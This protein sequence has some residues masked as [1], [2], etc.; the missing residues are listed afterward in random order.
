MN[1]AAIYFQ[2][3]EYLEPERRIFNLGSRYIYK[4]VNED[5]IL[6]ISRTVNS[7]HIEG[8]FNISESKND[9][10]L[11]S[12]IVGQ[13]GVGKSSI[14]DVIRSNFIKNEYALPRS[15]SMLLIED[16][17]KVYFISR[18]LKAPVLL[19]GLTSTNIATLPER[20]I[21]T[22]FY[23]PHLDLKFNPNF[24]EI[25]HFDI[26][27]DRYLEMD[28]LDLNR[29]Q[30]NE[31]GIDY[32]VKQELLFKRA[33]RQIE[34]MSS[35]MMTNNNIFAGTFDFPAHGNAVLE[36][37]GTVDDGKWRN[38]PS[39]FNSPLKSLQRLI[40]K[41][42]DQWTTI[43]TD[44]EKG[45]ISNQSEVNAYLFQRY[46][47]KDILSVLIHQME[48]R[49]DYYQKGK[50]NFPLNREWPSDGQTAYQAF[51]DYLERCNV[52]TIGSQTPFDP[53][54]VEALVDKLYSL[55]KE[56]NHK[57]LLS[58]RKLILES[59]NAIEVLRLH[60]EFVLE[61][62][63]YYNKQYRSDS[64]DFANMNF[65]VQGFIFYSPAR[66]KLSS[67]ENAVLNLFSK[68][69][70]LIENRHN[71][72]F[73]PQPQIR[74]YVLLLD[75]AD[76]GYH[77]I[78]KKKFVYAMARCL[79]HFF[80]RYSQKPS[81]QL[82]FTTHDPLTLSDLPN[83]NVVY[84]LNTGTGLSE[85]KNDKPKHTFAA[86]ITDLLAD[87]FFVGDG[88][89][90]DFA[91]EKIQETIKWLKNTQNKQNSTT[92]RKIISMIDEPIIKRKLAEMFDNKMEEEFQLELI[93]R[94]IN[95]LNKLK[96][97]IKKK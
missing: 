84:L 64:N 42:L 50:F 93:E 65:L 90:G 45:N 41:E 4:L 70:D 77:P 61:V 9:L 54:T 83:K 43:R 28:L 34:F 33:K 29:H 40:E 6:T 3:H 26:S 89:V 85:P 71:P 23:S 10:N 19:E 30:K 67:G 76:L 37:R 74:H 12:A 59:S 25:D 69:Y 60:K 38:V 78:W 2:D 95:E 82:I 62:S 14:L 27:M 86:N 8:F 48:Q 1:I 52:K 88:L 49:G 68:L 32:S 46:I 96:S 44:D 80:E 87:S 51:I 15:N 39:A 91:K 63:N 56:E 7:T 35:G 47:L 66:R 57:N 16:G 36:M 94:Q 92:Y 18:N 24:D 20:E 5:E 22:I 55:S 21:Q 11:I 31:Y 79:P 13:N 58:D 53:E 75:E 97:A 73:D 17:R 72:I 81:I